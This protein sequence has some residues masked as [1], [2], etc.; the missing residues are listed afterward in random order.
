MYGILDQGQHLVAA[1]N[2][3]SPE[4]KFE[5]QHNPASSHAH[6]MGVTTHDQSGSGENFNS[7]TYLRGNIPSVFDLSN[8]HVNTNQHFSTSGQVQGQSQQYYAPQLR[9]YMTYGHTGGPGCVGSP[10]PFSY[11]ESMY[12]STPNQLESQFISQF[13]QQYL[14]SQQTTLHSGHVNINP[15]L[16][17]S[18]EEVSITGTTDVFGSN[19]TGNSAYNFSNIPKPSF[20]LSTAVAVEEPKLSGE[21]FDEFENAGIALPDSKGRTSSKSQHICNFCGKIYSRR[22]GLKIH[23]RTHSGYKPLKCNFCPRTFSDPSN[24]NK[25]AKLHCQSSQ[26]TN[27]KTKTVKM[28]ENYPTADD[29][30]DLEAFISLATL[31][32]GA[33]A[34]RAKTDFGVGKHSITTTKIRD[35]GLRKSVLIVGEE[36]EE[37][38]IASCATLVPAERSGTEHDFELSHR[39]EN[40]FTSANS[41]SEILDF[42]DSSNQQ[43]YDFQF[44]FSS[45]QN[46]PESF[47]NDKNRQKRNH[48]EAFVPSPSSNCEN[49]ENEGFEEIPNAVAEFDEQNFLLEFA[50]HEAHFSSTYNGESNTLPFMESPTNDLEEYSSLTNPNS[51]V[52]R[53]YSDPGNQFVGANSFYKPHSAIQFVM[54]EVHNSSPMSPVPLIAEMPTTLSAIAASA[55]LR[56]NSMYLNSIGKSSI[57]SSQYAGDGISHIANDSSQQP[58][59]F[60]FSDSE[61]KD[62]TDR[63][64]ESC[65]GLFM[66]TNDV[67]SLQ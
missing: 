36:S 22:Y 60:Q 65:Y 5:D 67:Q 56:E 48:S 1:S 50:K 32:S 13:N 23:L 61:F 63:S 4:P 21:L 55:P 9:N 20:K 10:V 6:Q 47:E 52:Y 53:I 57:I 54:N 59:E 45:T 31:S 66:K 42:T 58:Q 39:S 7:G 24:L 38:N 46:D 29:D 25:H 12:T 14:P 43:Q 62:D 26:L 16:F 44:D 17:G 15:T 19:L 40:L 11:H 30:D 18:P 37:R 64:S 34:K 27:N 49:I 28:N 3:S 35:E 51:G 41:L 8:N 2:S 33:P